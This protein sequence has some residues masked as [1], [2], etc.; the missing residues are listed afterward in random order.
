MNLTPRQRQIAELVTQAKANKEIAALLG[1]TSGTV[2]IYMNHI[3]RRVNVT[4]RMELALMV[5]EEK[6][7]QKAMAIGAA[8][9]V[10]TE[11][12]SEAD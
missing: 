2:K 11:P 7:A 12:W 4:S 1:L 9:P 10:P 5:I 6:N 8:I 3:F